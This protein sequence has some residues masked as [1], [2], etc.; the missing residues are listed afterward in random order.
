VQSSNLH[1][2]EQNKTL[3]ILMD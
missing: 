1:G 3:M 2:S